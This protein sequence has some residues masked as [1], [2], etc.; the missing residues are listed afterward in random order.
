MGAQRGFTLVETLV[1]VA[2]VAIL[3]AAGLRIA[4][5]AR[6]PGATANAVVQIDAGIALARSLARASGNGAS[7]LVLPRTDAHGN[8]MQGFL[9]FVFRGRPSAPGAARLA[10]AL[11]LVGD[12]SLR[13]HSLGAPPFALFFRSDGSAAGL[14]HPALTG[15]A[16]DPHFAPLSA[17]PACVSAAGLLLSV[18]RN[19][20]TETRSIPCPAAANVTG[21]G[22]QP[23]MTPNPPTLAPHALLFRWPTAAPGSFS[24][25]EFGYRRWFAAVGGAMAGFAC[26]S[27]SGAVV[28]FPTTPPYS[29]PQSAADALSAPAPPSNAPYAFAASSS[30]APGAMDDAPASFPVQPVGAGLCSIPLVDAFGQGSDPWGNPLVV[31]VQVM[32]WLTLTDGGS[33]ATS[34]TAPLSA[35]SLSQGQSLTIT[36]SKTFDDDPAGITFTGLSWNPASCGS[37]L[38]FTASGNNTAGNGPT[39]TATHAFVITDQTPP[40]SALT[41]TGTLTDQYGEPTVSFTTNVAAGISAF[42]TWPAGGIIEATSGSTL[43]MLPMHEPLIAKIFGAEMADA[44]TS[45]CKAVAI[46]SGTFPVDTSG[47]AYTPATITGPQANGTYLPAAVQTLLTSN[48]WS[49]DS[50]GCVTNSN[51]TLNGQAPIVVYEPSGTSATYQGS[52]ISCKNVASLGQANPLSQAGAQVEFPVIPGSKA[53]S[54]TVTITA[55][56]APSGTPAPGSGLVPVQVTSACATLADNCLYIGMNNAA[57]SYFGA[58]PTGGYGWGAAFTWNGSSWVEQMAAAYNPS[59]Q[60]CTTKIV[61][62]SPV[63]TCSGPIQ[64]AFTQVVLPPMNSTIYTLG[65]SPAPPTV[66]QSAYS[67]YSS[68]VYRYQIEYSCTSENGVDGVGGPTYPTTQ[69]AS[70]NGLPTITTGTTGVGLCEQNFVGL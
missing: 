4:T 31:A 26:R 7:L 68:G 60:K 52:A 18:T 49:V 69:P 14:A 33:S 17:E 5:L 20:A 21:A 30:S 70:T 63:T 55:S 59:Y 64:P 22:P 27:Q 13:E 48:G 19:G 32:G 25:A 11:P 43:G 66:V 58:P 44:L 35:G 15:S 51:P 41:C 62:G 16:G 9:L 29:G 10:R 1:T 42:L 8:A 57:P 28:V 56:L 36:A 2:I 46:A 50:T 38:T 23:S 65:S 67:T 45:G 24:I 39:G 12:A 34:Q 61:F 3:F 40:A 6:A 54:C 47:T 37:A 53:G